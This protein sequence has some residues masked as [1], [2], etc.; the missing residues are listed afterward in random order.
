MSAA[1]SLPLT[2]FAP[3]ERLP[4]GDIARQVA[5]LDQLGGLS[6][7]L[8]SMPDLVMVL[9]AQRQILFGNRP[10]REFAA[11][12]DCQAF[13]G[14]R[15]GE[16][17]H[18]RHAAFAPSGC[19]TGE[20]CRT[21]GAVNAILA[22]LS[23]RSATH[24]CRVA[25]SGAEAID[26]R[27]WASPFRWGVRNYVLVVAADIGN[28][29]RRQVLERLFFHDLLNTASSIFGIAQLLVDDPE[30]A[31]DLTGDL[32]SAAEALIGE[33]RSQR[34]LLAAENNELQ[35]KWQPVRARAVLETVIQVSRN[36]PV[37]AGQHVMLAPDT[38]DAFIESDE[39]LLNR[40]LSNLLKNALEAGEPG[41]T[42]RL[43]ARLEP[44]G[45]V[46]WCWNRAEMP[47][48]HQWQVFQR[49]F[50]TKGP[51]RGV[52]TYSVKLLTER[53]LKG[54]ASFRSGA[55]EGTQFE[56]FFPRE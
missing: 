14:L 22:G 48:E 47:R 55:G 26:L 42:V 7:L 44:R 27:V 46:F 9:N 4:A 18:C 12:R 8:D 50:S 37:A 5:E 35:V 45:V 43:G 20:A 10:V 6:P 1:A 29:K 17:L 23:G 3:P 49:N 51:G 52:G 16:L 39:I 38:A 34:L 24:E 30:A 31:A 19:G 40:V 21:C 13:E 56:L 11:A 32:H 33:I 36:N 15:P 41:D 53:Y 54:R 28:E 25:T 2:F